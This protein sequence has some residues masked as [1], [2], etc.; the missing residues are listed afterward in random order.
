MRKMYNIELTRDYAVQ[1]QDDKDGVFPKR[2]GI[3]FYHTFREDLALLKAAGLKTFRTSISWA[4][5]FPDGDN[6]APNE[7]GLKFYDEL[8]DEIIKNGMEPMITLAHYEMPLN[9]ALK[10]N[11]W[12]N[13]Q[14]IDFYFN[15]ARTCLDRYHDRVKYWI[16]LT[17][18]TSFA[19]SPSI[20]WAFSRT[21]APIWNRINIRAFTTNWWLR[22][23]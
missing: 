1:A 5:I 11:G 7:A 21:K 19:T 15:F 20:I 23:W 17:R 9:L 16:P 8:I 12:K 6:K 4:R 10:Y 13:R 2:T 22:L 3:D 18:L 14:L